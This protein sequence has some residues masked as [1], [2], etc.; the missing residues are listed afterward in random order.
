MTRAPL[1]DLARCSAG[2][3]A[4]AAWRARLVVALVTL[5]AGGVALALPAAF[6]SPAPLMKGRLLV[7][8]GGKPLGF[9]YVD[10][11]KRI[12]ARIA[13]RFAGRGRYRVGPFEGRNDIVRIEL[14][15][16]QGDEAAVRAGLIEAGRFLV[17]TH[18]R[19]QAELFARSPYHALGWAP[20]EILGAPVIRKG[21]AA[22]SADTAPARFVLGSALGFAATVAGVWLLAGVDPSPSRPVLRVPLSAPGRLV[23][24][25]R[26]AIAGVLVV[27]ATLALLGELRVERRGLRTF[28]GRVVLR[29]G[30]Q[31]H[32]ATPFFPI[33]P[34]SSIERRLAA[35]FRDQ[36]FVKTEPLETRGQNASVVALVF[37]TRGDESAARAALVP[38]MEQA[39]AYL[40]KRHAELLADWTAFRI[41]LR[42]PVAMTAVV[43]GPDVV[44]ASSRMA[45]AIRA[46]VAGAVAAGAAVV[47]VW[48][49]ALDRVRGQAVMS[50]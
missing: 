37:E 34:A 45:L 48:L 15:D 32:P 14:E 6:P 27:A 49:V 35:L 26:I 19:M 5:V 20:T 11:V 40:V 39:A 50:W 7:R 43:R 21:D 22:A 29:V 2:D 31:E 17:E 44:L 16:A 8:V 13:T 3:L 23:W 42:P 41:P 33:E 4:R 1:L 30:G 38:A 10:T 24:R 47:A 25:A 9:V 28:V 12:Q 18:A 46:G 36:G